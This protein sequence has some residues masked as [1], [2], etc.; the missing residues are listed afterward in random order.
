MRKNLSRTNAFTLVELLVVIG[1]IAILIG[2]LLPSLQGAKNQANSVKC[3]SNMRQVYIELINYMNTYNGWLFPVGPGTPPRTYGADAATPP[4]QRWPMKVFKFSH[5]DIPAEGTEV[6][7]LSGGPGP[8]NPPTFDAANFSDAGPWTPPILLCPND[9]NPVAQHS[10][11]LNQH[12]AYKNIRYATRTP[13]KSSAEIVVMGEKKTNVADYYMEK[14]KVDPTTVADPTAKG[15]GTE[16]TRVVETHRHGVK[17]GSNYL[18]KDGHVDIVPP[19]GVE[20]AL[21]PWD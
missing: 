1:I 17:L 5:P 12:L 4:W 11:V 15:V 8:F 21:D 9:F 20:G 3:K 7:D 13:N 6:P 14:N 2:L 18:F 16:F 10:Y 19:N